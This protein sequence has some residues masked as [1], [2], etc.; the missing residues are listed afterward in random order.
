MMTTTHQTP[1]H[2]TS[3]LPATGTDPIGYVGRPDASASKK[4]RGRASGFGGWL[5]TP[6]N[7]ENPTGFP[8]ETRADIRRL[9][10]RAIA[11]FR[12]LAKAII[13]GETEDPRGNL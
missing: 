1:M 12:R 2:T 10:R 6:K 7:S 13:A 4:W 8:P 5:S 3:D 11:R 9:T